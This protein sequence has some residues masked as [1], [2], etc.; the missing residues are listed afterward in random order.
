LI[1]TI[2]H[3]TKWLR[4]GLAVG[5]IALG[6]LGVAAAGEA[7]AEYPNFCDVKL[8]PK[9]ECHGSPNTWHF[10]L[11]EMYEGK[12]P[13]CVTPDGWNGKNFYPLKEWACSSS[14][15]VID[16]FTAVYDYPTIYNATATTQGV[17]GVDY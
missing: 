14:S 16:E 5:L 11:A 17:V 8:K 4:I 1:T 7:R 15:L 10:L 3:G 9:T 12:T 6:V 13:L 2:S